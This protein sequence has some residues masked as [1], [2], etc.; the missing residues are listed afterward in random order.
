M[1]FP[2][3]SVVIPAYNEER[4]LRGCLEALLAQEGV[5]G[6]DIWVVPNGCTDRTAE[7]AR[8]FGPRVG[9]IELPE[10]SKHA[11]L[12]AGD[13]AC[14]T[15]PRVYAD[16]DVELSPHALRQLC[17]VLQEPT[18]DAAAPRLDYDLTECSAVVRGFYGVWSLRGYLDEH[19]VGSGVYALNERGHARVGWFPPIIADDGYVSASIPRE[20]RRSLQGCWFKKWAP[21]DLR[22]TF[23]VAVR[24]RQGQ[25]QLAEEFPHLKAESVVPASR[26]SW[27]RILVQ[28]PLS[29]VTYTVIRILALLRAKQLNRK[30]RTDV[31]LR[32]DS[33]RS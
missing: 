7:I 8:S 6:P 21:Q 16:A 33:S 2:R 10:G 23:K 5:E 14:T 15:F 31:W 12:N 27:G 19:H 11:A 24:V 29:L 3:P 32:D 22:S 1:G 13:R 17:S 18:I 25:L 20:R 30:G 4:H 26:V 9:V 28:H